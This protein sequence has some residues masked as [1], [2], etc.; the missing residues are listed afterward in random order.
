MSVPE[1]DISAMNQ[2]LWFLN[3]RRYKWPT[4]LSAAPSVRLLLC[5]VLCPNLLLTDTGSSEAT[6]ERLAP[7]RCTDQ[8][9]DAGDTGK[10]GIRDVARAEAPAGSS[11]AS[12][13]VS[14]Y[15][16]RHAHGGPHRR[17]RIGRVGK[18]SGQGK[19][20]LAGMLV[21]RSEQSCRRIHAGLVKRYQARRSHR[22]LPS[23]QAHRQC[24]ISNCREPVCYAYR[25]KNSEHMPI[26]QQT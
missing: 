2:R 13:S 7:R 10:G 21:M 11:R 20:V 14:R 19:F 24:D 23:Q 4:V 17:L 1:A 3:K 12:R 16:L 26:T 8:A 6:E 9:D 18:A 5:L 15:C 25:C 22:K